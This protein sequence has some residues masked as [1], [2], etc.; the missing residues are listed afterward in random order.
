MYNYVIPK[1][2]TKITYLFLLDCT[3]TFFLNDAEHIQHTL[4]VYG[5]IKQPAA[6]YSWVLTKTKDF[7]DNSITICQNFMNQAVI[8]YMKISTA[9]EVK[10]TG[11]NKTITVDISSMIADSTCRHRAPSHSTHKS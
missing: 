3:P 2:N 9:Q 7:K 11:S 5:C 4:T 1:I 6:W 10:C 8:K